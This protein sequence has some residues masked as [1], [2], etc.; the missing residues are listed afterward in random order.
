MT[1]E[2]T[3]EIVRLVESD[4]QARSSGV[5]QA[6]NFVLAHMV[7]ADTLKGGR[8]EDLVNVERLFSA[9]ELLAD[10]NN[11]E[12]APFVGSW[13]E[14][15]EAFDLLRRD[16]SS[17]AHRIQ[18][19]LA[20]PRGDI[21]KP[22]ADFI[23]AEVGRGQGR[24]YQRALDAMTAALRKAVHIPSAKTVQYLTPLVRAASSRTVAAIGSLNYDLSI[25]MAAA[26]AGTAYDTG[27]VNWSKEGF[28]N[29]R[30]DAFPLIKLHGSI[31]W[32]VERWYPQARDGTMEQ[33]VFV[34]TDDPLGD[35]RRPAVVFGQREKLRAEGPFLE[36]LRQFSRHLDGARFLIVIGY[37]FQDRHINEQI[38][39]WL[40]SER[41]RTITVID[42]HFPY[43]QHAPFGDFR[44]E[45]GV[46]LVPLDQP[47]QFVPR[48]FV[49]RMRANEGIAELFG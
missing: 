26:E 46:N 1:E 2:M 23:E 15:V 12:V 33:D 25:E 13:I 40:N 3:R 6:L 47:G 11:I 48:L 36:L 5:S 4:N 43:W 42:P 44:R 20:R 21:A 19:E 39:R 18:E 31:N 45:M 10:R 30:D 49:K 34:E 41:S 37:S 22:L 17:L 29:W 14:G 8:A 28:W 7:A 9:V 38:R 24:V 27:L 32:C 16:K 35:R